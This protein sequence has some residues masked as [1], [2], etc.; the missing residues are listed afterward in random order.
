MNSTLQRTWTAVIFDLDGTI[1][2]SGPGLAPAVFPGIA[3]LLES[4]H[5]SEVPLLLATGMQQEDAEAVLEQ[6]ELSSFFTVVAG[7]D[8]DAARSS[9][10]EIITYALDTFRAQGGDASMPVMVGDRIGDVEGATAN[11]VPAIIVEWGQ[12]SPSDAR[13]SIAT[14]YSADR[15]RE[16]LLGN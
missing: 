3:G 10:A 8:F 9:K 14:V 13:G 7:S 2:D 11:G 15:L 1:I 4:L 6:F 12:G 16:L 5:E